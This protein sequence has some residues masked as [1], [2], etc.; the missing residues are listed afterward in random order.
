[1]AAGRCTGTFIHNVIVNTRPLEKWKNVDYERAQCVGNTKHM[2][3]FTCVNERF[4]NTLYACHLYLAITIYTFKL[5]LAERARPRRAGMTTDIARTS[6]HGY[7][8]L[9]RATTT[10]YTWGTTWQDHNPYLQVNISYSKY[11]LHVD[12]RYS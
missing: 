7:S 8:T 5:T 9:T 6:D 10:V 3:V 4:V 2:R 11:I 12:V 1:M